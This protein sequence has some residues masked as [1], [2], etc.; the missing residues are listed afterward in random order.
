M[1][2]GMDDQEIVHASCRCPSFVLNRFIQERLAFEPVVDSGKTADPVRTG[3]FVIAENQTVERRQCQLKAAR[4][5][6][7]GSVP[8]VYYVA[9][10]TAPNA[11]R[12]AA[13]GLNDLGTVENIPETDVV[14]VRVPDDDSALLRCRR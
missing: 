6:S 14:A 3:S 12:F 13:I 8:A 5:V 4:V 7:L 1:K 2:P 11:T 10:V 9:N